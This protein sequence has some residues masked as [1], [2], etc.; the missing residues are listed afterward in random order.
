LENTLESPHDNYI[1]KA[2]VGFWYQY[3]EAQ[4][5]YIYAKKCYTTV[6]IFID[7]I[8]SEITVA[9]LDRDLCRKKNGG[10]FPRNEKDINE[11][12][13]KGEGNGKSNAL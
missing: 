9:N 6:K 8:V 12:L 7:T 11:I 10:P 3:I 13:P 1:E 5:I 2:R 4:D